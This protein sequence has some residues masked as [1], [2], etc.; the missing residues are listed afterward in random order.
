MS[1]PTRPVSGA[2]IATD[3]G[4]EIHDRVLA[5]SGCDVWSSGARSTGT[6]A[7]KQNI[8]MAHS[9]PG[10]YLDAANDQVVIPTGKEGLYLVILRGQSINGSSGT[11]NATRALLHVN[12]T[13]VASGLEDNQDGVAVSIIVPYLQHFSA[14]DIVQVW[15]QR[16]GSGS[17]PDFN[18]ASLQ[19]VRITD[20]YGA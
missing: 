10:G 4:D 2:A 3:W 8:D 1:L 11:N 6:T 14:G 20:D 17:N 15:A 7:I 5:A 13:N 19:L 9:D 18:V 16:R 12:G